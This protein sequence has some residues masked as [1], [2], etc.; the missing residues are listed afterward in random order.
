MKEKSPLLIKRFLRSFNKTVSLGVTNNKLLNSEIELEL[1]FRVFD[2]V[3][4]K[5]KKKQHNN[6]S[7]N[8]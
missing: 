7:L 2:S 4:E 5:N 1:L 6:D 8:I 3:Q